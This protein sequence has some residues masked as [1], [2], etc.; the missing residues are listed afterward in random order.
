MITRY[1]AITT[2]MLSNKEAQKGQIVNR[3]QDRILAIE[4]SEADTKYVDKIRENMN[5][6]R[7]ML[8]E[9]GLE[10]FDDDCEL[11]EGDRELKLE[12]RRTVKTQSTSFERRANSQLIMHAMHGFKEETK[13]PEDV[14]EEK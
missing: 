1:N 9:F 6:T 12:E 7:N 3:H 4:L 8:D 13:T 11:D 14:E 10:D 2:T 5:I